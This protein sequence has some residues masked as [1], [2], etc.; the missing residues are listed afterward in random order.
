LGV[1]A[2][3]NARCLIYQFQENPRPDLQLVE[4]VPSR[5]TDQLVAGELDAGIISSIECFRH[6]ELEHLETLGI[7][8]TGA[9]LSVKLFAR[10]PLDRV[11]TVALDTSSRTA[12]ALTRILFAERWGGDPEFVSSPPDLNAMLSRC[13]AALLIGD[14]ALRIESDIQ[15]HDLGS[16]W[17]EHTGLPFVYAIWAGRPGVFGSGLGRRLEEAERYGSRHIEEIVQKEAHP[18]AIGL[19]L[20]RTYLSQVIRHR[21]TADD[22]EG[23]AR[24]LESA[25]RLGLL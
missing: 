21:L 17:L 19:P 3:L 14:P 7:A 25:R 12:A 4:D 1:V 23:L 20:C 2:Y 13:D 11:Q 8:C 24:Y 22:R 6:P 16:E 15:R 18:R 10:A 5:L 9:V